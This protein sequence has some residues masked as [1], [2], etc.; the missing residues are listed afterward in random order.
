MITRAQFGSRFS[1]ADID[2]MNAAIDDA[3]FFFDIETADLS[4]RERLQLIDE[5]ETNV[6]ANFF[7]GQVLYQTQDLLPEV[8]QRLLASRTR[9]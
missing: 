5:I 8:Y 4:E 7:N 9:R 1:Q 3:I 2:A 6:V